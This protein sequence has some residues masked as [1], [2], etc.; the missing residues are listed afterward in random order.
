M[1]R[2]LTK[3][4]DRFAESVGA[5]LRSAAT[6]TS[7]ATDR[8]GRDTLLEA[9][10]LCAALIDVDGRHTDDELWALVAAFAGLD[11]TRAAY[12]HAVEQRYRFY[13]YGD[14]MLIL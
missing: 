7:V 3:A 13:S 8:L 2:G 5:A 4:V 9:F 12:R 11:R 10:N 6:G 1:D 14:A